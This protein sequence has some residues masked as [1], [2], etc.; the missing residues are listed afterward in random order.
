MYGD[1]KPN[2][3]NYSNICS[4]GKVEM[5]E[6]IKAWLDTVELDLEKQVHAGLCLSLAEM[7]DKD[8]LTSTAAE[9]RR[10][11]ND[12]KRLIDGSAVEIDPLAEMLK[13]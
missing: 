2:W 7:F 10:A 8:H 1:R 9:L 13:R 12:L 11:V 6:T 3:P 5:H 4:K